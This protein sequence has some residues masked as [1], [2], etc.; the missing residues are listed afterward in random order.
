MD[1]W[2]GVAG[3]IAWIATA[4]VVGLLVAGALNSYLAIDWVRGVVSLAAGLAV[5][6]FLMLRALTFRRL[7]EVERRRLGGRS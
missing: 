5:A 6:G 2:R 7:V 1:R 4:L 3:D